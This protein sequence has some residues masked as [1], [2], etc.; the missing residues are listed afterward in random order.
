VDEDGTHEN[1][2]TKEITVVNV[3]PTVSIVG[4]PVSSPEGTAINLTATVTDPGTDTFT[5]AWSVTKAGS[6]YATGS[7][8][9][10]SFTPDD[11]LASYVVSLTVTDDDTG[12]GV[13]PAQTVSV[14]NVAPTIALAGAASVNE[15]A[16]YTL[17]LGAITDPGTD[18]VTQWIVDWGDGNSDTYTTP[19]EKTHV[20]ADDHPASGTP[21]DAF[22]ITVDLVDEDGTHEN[23]GTKEITVVNVPPNLVDTLPARQA[24]RGEMVVLSGATFTDPGE[25][26]ESYAAT[27]NWGDG[28]GD[29]PGIV[30][31]PS[32]GQAG[33]VDGSHVYQTDGNYTVI[34]LLSDDDLG[35]DTVSFSVTIASP[36]IVVGDH[37]LLAGAVNPG[38]AIN[39]TGGH[40]VE[41]VDLFVQVADGGLQAIPAGTIVG[42]TVAHVDLLGANAYP[43]TIFTGNHTG[44]A[45]GSV[46][47]Q[48]WNSGTTTS[49]GTVS[50]QGRLATVVIDATAFAATDPNNPFDL[51]LSGTVMG[52]TRFGEIL[53]N[54]VNGRLIL[55]NAPTAVIDGPLVVD[56]GTTVELDGSDSFAWAVGDSIVSYEWDLDGDGSFETTGQ[57]VSFAAPDG[58]ATRTVRLRV[59]DNNYAENSL[60]VDV[61]TVEV[62][63][64]D[65]PPTIALTGADSVNEGAIY[66][67]TLG[68]ITD[69]G[70]DTGT[71]WI[72]YWGDG[73][74]DTYTS[75]G[76][77]T[78][79]YADDNPT[80]SSSDPHS[81]SVTLVNE[82]GT[83]ADAGGKIIT[84][85]NVAPDVVDSVPDQTARKNRVV[86]LPSITF[87]DPGLTAETYTATVNWGDGSGDQSAT[88]TKP[89][90]GEPGT[91][92]ATHVYGDDGTYGVT[93]TVKDDD[94]GEDFVSFTMVIKSGEV[95]DRWIFY[96]NSY[97][98]GNNPAAN[99]ADFNAIAPH[100]SITGG[101]GPHP[102]GKDEA[103]KELGK[104]ALLPGQTA[105]FANYTSY[106]KGINGIMI[107]MAGL[108][109]PLTT[110]DF[111]FR[112]GNSNDPSAWAVAPDPTSITI[113][114]GAGTPDSE[115]LPT[116]RI[117][118]IWADSAI[119]KTWLQITV[120]ATENT[121]LET[122]DV[123]YFGN[124]IGESGS[125]N[126]SLYAFVTV[127]DEL[128]ART[129][130][131]NFLNRA[132]VS[133][134]TDFNKDSFVT[135]SD[136]LLARTNG[137]SFLNALKLITVPAAPAGGASVSGDGGAVET[138]GWFDD[139][140][141]A[142]DAGAAGASDLRVGSD[143]GAAFP[144]SGSLRY[145]AF[146][147]AATSEPKPAGI[148]AG[149]AAERDKLFT[150]WGQDAASTPL[151]ASTGVLD[152]DELEPLLSAQED[153]E[154]DPAELELLDDVF[155]EMEPDGM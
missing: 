42:P 61:A 64:V 62:T 10:F 147:G 33:M 68:A 96:N 84:V 152:W 59:M 20:Y 1:A 77:K 76:D 5:Y 93:V 136:E 127:T 144:P 90:S 43:A 139:F 66:T 141:E 121:A 32:G 129:H 140:G 9:A 150:R 38:F 67:L 81:I 103:A 15:G 135:V 87:T 83:H 99:P 143:W 119:R 71:E 128:A 63:I 53:P 2:G 155:A 75:G 133:D 56:E 98:D 31:K 27:I 80:N 88:V 44:A 125:G 12:V 79:V 41:G 94:G 100:T 57:T 35:Q 107:D 153:G 105:S 65:V 11:G 111:Q 89:S 85:H 123:F 21:S 47:P 130:P 146:V 51:R 118:L 115:G 74:S 104:D 97:Y 36:D 60:F 55:K 69:P 151:A 78:H 122:P 29:Q 124:A 25:S 30:T 109:G 24:S 40:A 113:F 70:Q 91:I 134:P 72:V 101:H 148:A 34:V 114:S 145:E 3:A 18:T 50:A 116:D 4:A 108:D 26:Y 54:V 131:H 39:V 22:T 14:T 117:T 13:A 92:N 154:H 52:D 23:A 102:T 138:A 149:A 137:T 142:A 19:G 73:T 132:L 6:P 48:F 28:T 46:V 112:V 16:T 17:T 126:T 95:V 106:S 110:A 58:P 86:A 120:L 49:S 8:A 37:V 82:D 7:A 45:G